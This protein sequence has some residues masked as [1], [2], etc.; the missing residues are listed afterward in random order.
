MCVSVSVCE[1]ALTLLVSGPHERVDHAL[2]RSM[3]CVQ[4]GM[5]LSVHFVSVSVCEF[6]LTLLLFGPHERVDH[7]LLRSA[8]ARER[9]LHST[10]PTDPHKCATGD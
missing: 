7:A 9:A 2:L 6:A 5:Q 10:T 4:L 3:Y 8:A 1:F